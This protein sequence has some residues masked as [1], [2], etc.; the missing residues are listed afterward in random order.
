M[1]ARAR[2]EKAHVNKLEAI[3]KD[4]AACIKRHNNTQDLQEKHVQLCVG[5]FALRLRGGMPPVTRESST[6]VTRQDS[7]P[8]TDSQQ[9]A[10][11]FAAMELSDEE[12]DE[13]WQCAFVKP[14]GERCLQCTA[15]WVLTHRTHGESPGEAWV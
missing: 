9:A 15:H 1:I 8:P 14:N 5:R 4:A 3:A 11:A 13:D 10:E 2:A 6:G 7:L 12:E